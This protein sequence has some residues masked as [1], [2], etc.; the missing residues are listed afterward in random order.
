VSS[1]ADVVI[2]LN[3]EMTE[4]TLNE[5]SRVNWENG[6][7]MPGDAGVEAARQEG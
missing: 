3:P 6:R 7:Y 5:G 2:P 4:V 1:D